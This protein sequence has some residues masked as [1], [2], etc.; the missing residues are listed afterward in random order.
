MKRI[1][2]IQIFTLLNPNLISLK[3]VYLYQLNLFM[4]QAFIF[5]VLFTFSLSKAQDLISPPPTVANTVKNQSI[6]DEIIKVTEFENYFNQY[7][8]RKI[9]L[10]ANKA[11]WDDNTTEKV[12]RSVNFKFYKSSIYNAFAFDSEKNLKDILELFKNVNKNRQ[13]S[14]SKLFP[15]DALLQYNLEGYLQMV[16]DGKYIE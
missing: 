8:E 3:F 2:I 4:K 10:E 1:N 9:K 7:C 15:F 5:F 11:R 16:I 12:I 6:I 14:M 13:H